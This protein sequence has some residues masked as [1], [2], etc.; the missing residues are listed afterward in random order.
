[1]IKS[2]KYLGKLETKIVG[3]NYYEND[4][5]VG[6][7]VRFSR[8]PANKH[9]ENAI[10]VKNQNLQTVGHL[11]REHAAFLAPLMDDKLIKLEASPINIEEEW[12]IPLSLNIFL[13]K[14]GKKILSSSKQDDPAFVIHDQVCAFFKAS[15]TYSGA[16]IA[17]VAEMYERLVDKN[18]LPQT[19]L[20]LNLLDWKKEEAG[21]KEISMS[22]QKP[23][24]KLIDNDPPPM[25]IHNWPDEFPEKEWNEAMESLMDD[26]AN[27]LGPAKHHHK[28]KKKK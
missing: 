5:R 21:K 10:E 4:I 22:T 23:S 20:L 9:D 19:I 14:S 25:S 11:S 6:E 26:Q 3:I 8:N 7:K 18:T 24:D 12:C 2:A 13:T 1:M 16:T 28:N 17:R 27:A 15:D